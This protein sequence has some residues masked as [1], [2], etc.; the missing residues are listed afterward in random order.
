[1]DVEPSTETTALKDQIQSGEIR[2]LMPSLPA[3]DRTP[4]P[5]QI[6]EWGDAPALMSLYGRAV[7]L[8]KLQE[9]VLEKKSRL[10][11]V[12][13]MGG[14]GKTALAATFARCHASTFEVLLWRSLL[15][16]PPL[17]NVL[18]SWLGRLTSEKATIIPQSLDDKLDLLFSHLQQKRCLLI[19]DNAESIMESG[20]HAEVFREGY[21]A[22]DQLLRRFALSEHQ[23]CLLLTSR[24]KPNQF[25]QLERRESHVYSLVLPGLEMAAGF[26]I[27]QEETLLG[28]EEDMQRLVRQYSGNPLALILIADT[29]NDLYN[30]D[31]VA[32]LGQ[33]RLSSK[34]SNLC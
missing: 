30:G 22:Y 1:L 17:E 8:A 26:A 29:I 25:N 16:A 13:G 4:S 28:S 14:Q 9:E 5:S 18:Q 15:N 11:A 24:E 10:V 21:E 33:K 34:T 23:S 20:Q 3:A 27:L 19:L 32:F 12:L 7:E 31:I 6:V 2:R